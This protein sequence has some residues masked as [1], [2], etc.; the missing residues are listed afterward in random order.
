MNPEYKKILIV[1][2]SS[3]G[4]IVITSPIVR[5]VKKQLGT[6]VHF[7]TKTKFKSVVENNP[8]IDKVLLIDKE[9]TEIIDCLKLERYDL[10]IDLHKNLRSKR[11]SYLLGVK[12]ISFD[13][14]NIQKWLEVHLS[15]DFL[16]KVHLVDRY[17]EGVKQIGIN[18][19]GEG[20][21]YFHGIRADEISKIIPASKYI[22]LV[23]GATY[24]TKRI[25]IEKV[26]IIIKNA[27]LPIVLLGGNDV[28]EEANTLCANHKQLIN[29]V[30][31]TSLNE[32]ACIVSKS[33]FVI[34]GDTG[35]MHIAAAYKRPVI[36]FWG[37]TNI[38]LGMYPFFGKNHPKHVL[39]IINRDINCSPCSKIGKEKCPKSHFKCMVD[40]TENQIKKSLEEIELKKGSD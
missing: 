26:E 1:R 38:K 17:F 25:P 29:K 31:K 35:L 10:I 4:D 34:T 20:L 36:V 30:G 18:D 9:I 13:K 5:A 37:S 23:L 22:A 33:T 14:I 39:H 28:K 21:D 6:E 3:I 11:L 32:S 12:S 8:N 40:I 24:M 2:F 15:I 7:I 19:D 16:P 27:K